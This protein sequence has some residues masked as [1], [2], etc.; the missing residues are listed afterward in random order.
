M[1]FS[2]GNDLRRVSSPERLVEINKKHITIII[3]LF[4]LRPCPLPNNTLP[5]INLLQMYLLFKFV[6]FIY[7]VLNDS[8]FPFPI[9]PFNT[10]GSLTPCPY[11]SNVTGAP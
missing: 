10:T 1:V 4:I 8:I 11:L 7:K 3:L 2:C 6:Y 9:Y 5:L